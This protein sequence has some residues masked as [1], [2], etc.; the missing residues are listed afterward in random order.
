MV[1]LASFV[2]GIVLIV[3][4]TGLVILTCIGKNM[5]RQK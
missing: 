2:V 4:F 3:I 5:E 1:H